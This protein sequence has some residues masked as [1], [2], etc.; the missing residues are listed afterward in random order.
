VGS[1]CNVKLTK[2][3]VLIRQ[4]E[5]SV[6]FSFLYLVPPGKKERANVPKDIIHQTASSSSTLRSRGWLFPLLSV[7]LAL[8]F[9]SPSFSWK[10]AVFLAELSGKNYKRL[11]FFFFSFG[12]HLFWRI[13]LR[14]GGSCSWVLRLVAG[15]L[16]FWK[17]RREGRVR[18]E[19]REMALVLVYFRI[20]IF[21]LEI[22]KKFRIGLCQ[23]C[24]R[25]LTYKN[26]L[27]TRGNKPILQG[28]TISSKGKETRRF[29]LQSSD[30]YN[31]RS[32]KIMSKSLL[33]SIEACL[34]LLFLRLKQKRRAGWFEPLGG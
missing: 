12:E 20:A 16:Q 29:K 32:L 25:C 26:P 15:P 30:R 24:S 11:L 21:R 27:P 17:T 6:H 2:K 4:V 5:I 31:H 19:K 3:Y 28:Q 10:M 8:S 14:R 1:I 23:N 7:P 34:F 18:K 9:H 13:V 33:L 22:W